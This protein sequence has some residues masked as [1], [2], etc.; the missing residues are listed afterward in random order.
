[1][2][3]KSQYYVAPWRWRDE[4][5]MEMRWAGGHRS[6]ATVSEKRAWYDSIDQGVHPRPRRSPPNLADSWDDISNSR[7]YATSWKDNH[8]CRKQWMKTL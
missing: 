3:T 6:I 1:M 4:Y 5:T 7:Y 2:K 8:R